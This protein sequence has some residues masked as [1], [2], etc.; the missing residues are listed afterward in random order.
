MTAA[1]PKIAISLAGDHS[2]YFRDRLY[3]DACF[4]YEI[5]E[6]AS[7]NR[8]RVAISNDCRF[9]IGGG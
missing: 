7:R 5:I 8:I 9:D 1:F 2:L 3:V 4:A 6:A